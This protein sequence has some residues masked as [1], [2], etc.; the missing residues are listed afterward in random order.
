MLFCSARFEKCFPPLLRPLGEN[1]ALPRHFS[2]TLQRRSEVRATPF[3]SPLLE[4]SVFRLHFSCVTIQ[5]DLMDAHRTQCIF[6]SRIHSHNHCR[7]L[8]PIYRQ[9][10]GLSHKT[11][12]QLSETDG[13]G[14]VASAAVAQYKSLC[15]KTAVIRVTA[16][17]G[18][19][20][21]YNNS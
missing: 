18:K 21:N 6:W 3:I 14:H 19:S 1:N 7:S 16:S 15:W 12:A 2:H 13:R 5:S 9:F 8:A 4:R 20:I 11:L 10:P 17:S